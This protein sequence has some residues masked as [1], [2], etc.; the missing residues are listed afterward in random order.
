MKRFYIIA[1]LIISG[2]TAMAQNNK[3]L[4][5]QTTGNDDRDVISY[6]TELLQPFI[7]N[8]GKIEVIGCHRY[9][10]SVIITSDDFYVWSGVIGKGHGNVIQYNEFYDD[11][12]YLIT[13]MSTQGSTT[14]RL[15]NGV[16][17]GSRCPN[18]GAELNTIPYPKLDR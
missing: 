1:I 11:V 18:W 5:H 10:Y 15:E 4:A 16:L 12:T 2:M 9:S 3:G 14:W 17:N 7:N 6:Y 13:L 8:D